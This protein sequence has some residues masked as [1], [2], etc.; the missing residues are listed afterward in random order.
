LQN[1]RD[2]V[3]DLLDKG[4]IKKSCFQYASPTFLVRKPHGGHAMVVDYRLLNKKVFFD[5]LPMPTVEHAFASF[6]NARV[7][8][9]TDLNSAYYES[10]L[11]AKSLTL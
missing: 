3:Q 5:E 10:P 8:S 7:F 1:F 9:V 2:I 6:H 4:V 11:S